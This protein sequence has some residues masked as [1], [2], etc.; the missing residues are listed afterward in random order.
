MTPVFEEPLKAEMRGACEVAL[1]QAG[2]E[3]V[4]KPVSFVLPAS[5]GLKGALVG[6]IQSLDAAGNRTFYHLRPGAID[7]L[8]QWLANLARAS[9]LLRE[10]EFYVVVQQSTPNLE[11]SCRAAGAGLLHLTDTGEMDVLISYESVTPVDVGKATADRIS[12]LRRQL[13]GKMKLVRD[14]I[15]SR[16]QQV[17]SIVSTLDE[18]VADA[19]VTRVETDYRVLDDWGDTLSRELDSLNVESSEADFTAVEDLIVDGPK[20]PDEAESA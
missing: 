10:G 15:S 18:P 14:D 2:Y 12:K 6:D 5:M 3:V 19:Y 17:R 8:P 7:V 13:D 4:A 20:L 9:H 16:Y 11:R 1:D